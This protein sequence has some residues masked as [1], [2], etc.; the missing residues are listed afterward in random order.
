MD[1]EGESQAVACTGEE[2]QSLEPSASAKKAFQA[3]TPSQKEQAV[4][5]VGR[6]LLFHGSRG[7]S[8]SRE[9]LRKVLEENTRALDAVVERAAAL[10]SDIFGYTVVGIFGD[11]KKAR[12]PKGY[13]LMNELEHGGADDVVDLGLYEEEVAVL[14]P[15]LAY[16]HIKRGECRE[17]HLFS[18]LETLK[19]P[20]FM[21]TRPNRQTVEDLL[22][23]VFIQK[24]Y[25][26]RTEDKEASDH[27]KRAYMF[28]WGY[29]A[30]H[31]IGEDQ[32]KVYIGELLGIPPEEAI[33]YE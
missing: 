14:M 32:I 33:T 18:F 10:L 25:L 15:V 12:T 6:I 9:K 20:R 16:I 26:Q 30:Y 23:K 24:R 5:G 29:R 13:M 17:A 7:L 19:M 8:I 11:D 1:A 21:S 3:M 2:V 22:T 4:S 27:Q 31:E 28:S